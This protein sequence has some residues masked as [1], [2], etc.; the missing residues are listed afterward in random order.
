VAVVGGGIGGLSAAARLAR[1]GHAV[2][3]FEAQSEL[4]GK[5]QTWSCDGIT[6][7]LG[8]TLLTL[9]NVVR[10]TF[11]AL[12]SSDLLPTFKS[13]PLQCDY[14]FADGQRFRT[15]QDLKRSSEEAEALQSGEGAALQRFYAEA[16][17]IYRA[18]GEP[19]LEAP[20]EGMAG[21]MA[22]VLRR[23]I[24]SVLRGARLST[25]DALARRHFQTHALRQF[26]G[27][28]ATYVG[29]SPFTASA[30]FSL[31]A[32]LEQAEGV[33]HVEGGMGALA[34][35]LVEATKR[36]GV[37]VH[38]GHAAEWKSCGGEFRV[39]AGDVAEAFDALVLN[40]DPLSSVPNPTA[41]LSLSGYV[42][43]LEVK[44]RAPLEHHTVLFSR[45]Y[46][47]EF[48]ALVSGQLPEDC[49]ADLTL[50]V[51]RP[52]ATDPTMSTA[53]REGLYVMVNAPTLQPA[54]D[55]V[56][57]AARLQDACVRRIEQQWPTL[58][59]R[60]SVLTERTPKDFRRLGAPRGS[61]YGY[62]PEGRFG[63]F[64][65][66]PMRG[67]QPGLFYVGGGTHPGG[68]VPMA[69]LSGRFVAKMVDD[70]LRNAGAR[71]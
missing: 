69:M 26:V 14:H 46:P 52:A 28:F 13:L 15:F 59:G 1:L 27:R 3:L 41:P 47:A 34:R 40:S 57:Q 32:H 30:A 53:E 16:E 42:L 44:G 31:I 51:C 25:L 66:P 39:R 36:Q 55:F 12:E 71:A 68:G 35:A 67:S 63:P 2:T 70:H 22:R 62:A 50:Y 29:A 7:D 37:D 24:G 21:F 49:A 64:R 9:P 6:L 17:A 56:E 48:R 8:P 11:G 10:E 20:Y 23:G 65:R 43:L 18:A 61:I 45:D 60:L 54:Q 38:L 5:A 33:H 19:Y 4:G 58:R